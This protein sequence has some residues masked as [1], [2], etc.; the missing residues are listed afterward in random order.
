MHTVSVQV[1]TDRW[2][3]DL[4]SPIVELERAKADKDGNPGRI[5]PWRENVRRIYEGD[6]RFGAYWRFSTFFQSVMQWTDRGWRRADDDQIAVDRTAM[7]RIYGLSVS[8]AMHQDGFSG[9]L[10]EHRHNEAQE[11]LA[12][13]RWD[14]VE[15]LDGW[16]ADHYGCDEPMAPVYGRKWMIQAAARVMQPGCDAQA[17]LVLKAPQGVGKSRGIR[18]LAGELCGLPMAVTPAVSNA[19]SLTSYETTRTLCGTLFC[20]IDELAALK[21]ASVESVKHWLT[22]THDNNRR[23]H[24]DNAERVPRQWVTIATTND[25]SFLRDATGDRRFWVVE[26]THEC[27]VKAIAAAREQLWA[28]AL[29]RYRAGEPWWLTK[30]QEAQRE[31]ANARYRYPGWR[32][33]EVRDYVW[34]EGGQPRDKVSLRAMREHFEVHLRVRD[35]D[36]AKA[37][38]CLELLGGAWSGAT[39]A[40]IEG[41]VTRYFA[42][43]ASAPE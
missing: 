20:V 17:T 1:Q 15:R 21:S 41:R 34:P 13:L 10:T 37:K 43:P 26:A 39:K 5:K 33:D 9:W 29:H 7:E 38:R 4:P 2:G 16:L 36:E 14:G 27:D 35:W 8:N 25:S 3:D 32:E 24:R 31:R 12:G 6:E 42:M 22:E 30:D 23:M 18:A 28:E 11:W 19:Q 40:W